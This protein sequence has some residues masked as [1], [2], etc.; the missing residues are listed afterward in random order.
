[1][2]TKNKIIVI[3]ILNTFVFYSI[4][5]F[6]SQFLVNDLKKKIKDLNPD[7]N[8]IRATY[9]NYKNFSKNKALKIFEEYAAPGSKY[10]SFTGYRRNMF[11]GEVVNLDDNGFRISI[12]H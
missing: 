9:P 11:S 2:I 4:V 12:N 10:Q 3:I 6:I 5:C 8:L 1:M 7:T